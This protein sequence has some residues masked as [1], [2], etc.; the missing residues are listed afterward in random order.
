MF[1]ELRQAGTMADPFERGN[2]LSGSEGGQ[3]LLNQTQ[4]G[5][6]NLKER[7]CEDVVLHLVMLFG[8]CL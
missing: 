8:L 5:I 6:H 7:I 2:E 1:R 3:Q 4:S